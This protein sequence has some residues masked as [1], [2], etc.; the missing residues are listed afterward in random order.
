MKIRTLVASA[1]FLMSFVH[2]AHA[3]DGG[4]GGDGGGGASSGSDSSQ[5]A[6]QESQDPPEPFAD[7]DTPS[8]PV[9][10]QADFPAAVGG[11]R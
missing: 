3:D 11:I 8:E 7:T 6:A 2:V 1:I 5:A 9:P 10:P 4:G